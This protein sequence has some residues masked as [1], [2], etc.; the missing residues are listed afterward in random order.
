MA[1][2]F[3][4]EQLRTLELGDLLRH[5]QTL[6]K[7]KYPIQLLEVSEKMNQEKDLEKYVRQQIRRAQK[8]GP[9]TVPVLPNA[10]TN[11]EARKQQ[12]ERLKNS[13][14]LEIIKNRKIQGR[15]KLGNKPQYIDA[16]LKDEFGAIAV[17][18]QLQARIPTPRIARI[19]TP[20]PSPR[21][22]REQQQLR[23]L[24]LEDD[25][26]E[27]KTPSETE[28]E[29]CGEHR[30]VD[31]LEMDLKQLQELLKEKGID[32]SKVN[33]KEKAVDLI[34][35]YEKHKR[36]CDEQN[37]YDCGDDLCNVTTSPG[38]CVDR[39]QAVEE[40]KWITYKGHQI[41][42]SKDAIE[43]LQQRLGLVN[44]EITSTAA[45]TLRPQAKEVSKR[46]DDEL[47]YMSV[48]DLAALIEGHEIK[49]ERRKK[50][51]HELAARQVER[52][53]AEHRLRES[54]RESAREPSKDDLINSLESAGIPRIATNSLSMDALQ[55]MFDNL[56]LGI[57]KESPGRRE[58]EE[59][60]REAAER[61][62]T[63][64]EEEETESQQL[65]IVEDLA[66]E[67]KELQVGPKKEEDFSK[68][69][70]KVLKCLGLLGTSA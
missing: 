34:C 27:L 16:I 70:R 49:E 54:A 63:A 47:K 6:E 4:K 48:N 28:Y 9:I 53:E 5:V 61:K 51:I 64:K 52:K 43:A 68:I 23:K 20:P 17:Q 69:Q 3:T 45:N 21:I 40:P 15:S 14:L 56:N 37:Q 60:A 11:V 62:L 35:Q 1:K 57:R 2:H 12:L 24:G 65:D 33:S 36:T 13:E 42:G 44:R 46:S 67:V 22:A 30:Y 7:A 19:P 29:K 39:G 10:N 38:I 31:L 32:A 50:R 18:P 26:E 59:A 41:V 55:Q 66:R 8:A 25:D 58:R